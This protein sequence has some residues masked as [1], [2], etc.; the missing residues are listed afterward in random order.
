MPMESHSAWNEAVFTAGYL[1]S[2]PSWAPTLTPGRTQN[3]ILCV[4]HTSGRWAG[5]WV[6]F[7]HLAWATGRGGLQPCPG[8]PVR[9]RRDDVGGPL[10]LSSLP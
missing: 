4:L 9:A 7:P 6:L 2:S 3:G 8:L 5:L 1:V 10:V